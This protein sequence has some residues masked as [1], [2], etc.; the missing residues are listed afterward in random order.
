MWCCFACSSVMA[1]ISACT[2]C[3]TFWATDMR[4]TSSATA[5]SICGSGMR[6][7]TTGQREVMWTG[8]VLGAES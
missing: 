3:P 6:L 7:R 4:P 2:I 8:S 5:A 1:S